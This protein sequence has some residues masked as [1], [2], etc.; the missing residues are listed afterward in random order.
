[1]N[2]FE[3]G[4]I[5][6]VPSGAA[7]GGAICK[8]H[9]ILGIAGG[10]FAGMVSG[11]LVGWLYAVVVIVLL[12]VI[13][14]IWRRARKLPDPTEADMRAMSHRAIH[15]VFM[16]AVFAFIFWILF[17]WLPALVAAF[18]IVSVYTFVAVAQSITR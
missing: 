18:A 17:G 16:G 2:I 15:G 3:A 4:I 5:S 6:G 14:G 1:M 12:A 13:G 10:V 7:I 9:G 11:G 8:S